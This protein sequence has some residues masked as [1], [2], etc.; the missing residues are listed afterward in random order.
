MHRLVA[1]ATAVWMIIPET[2]HAGMPAENIVSNG[3]AAIQEEETT[4]LILEAEMTA[5]EAED[6]QAAPTAAAAADIPHNHHPTYLLHA[7]AEI[8]KKQLIATLTGAELN[9]L[10]QTLAGVVFLPGP[11]ATDADAPIIQHH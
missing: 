5:E 7:I 11:A 2:V 1:T 3:I 8:A 6:V 10:P 9:A 4:V